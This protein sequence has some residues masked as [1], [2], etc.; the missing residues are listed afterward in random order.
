M[1]F[2]RGYFDESG[3]HDSRFLVV[4]GLIGTVGDWYWFEQ[5]WKAALA[6]EGVTGPFHMQHLEKDRKNFRGW[7]KC[8]RERLLGKLLPIIRNR[9]SLGI[10]S[11]VSL[12]DYDSLI[13]P[14]DLRNHVGS[15][16][17]LCVQG[18]LWCA[19][20][21]AQRTGRFDEISYVLD[22]GHHNAEEAREAHKK[23]RANEQTVAE[24]RAGP[25]AFETDDHS[26][27]L[28]AA[29]VVAYETWKYLTNKSEEPGRAVRYTFEQLLKLPYENRLFD[30]QPLQEM[31][32]RY[33]ARTSDF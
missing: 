15:A 32:D 33:Q 29:D 14:G 21:W 12:E 22:S 4:A 18:V 2:Y 10:A 1:A 17:T 7:A 31:R 11:A 13:T 23:T 26:P 20:K 25:L 5:E 27:A 9:A 28:Q 6:C 19:G 16:Y 30:K 8:R 24:Y 3:S